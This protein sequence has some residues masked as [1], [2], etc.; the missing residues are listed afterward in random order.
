M[1]VDLAQWRAISEY[2]P[3]PW[4]LEAVE[5]HLRLDPDIS[6]RKLST[7]TGWTTYA[8]R[9][10]ISRTS[11]AEVAQCAAVECPLR[12]ESRAEVA[13]VSRSERVPSSPPPN[14][15]PHT[16][17]LKPPTPPPSEKTDRQRLTELVAGPLLR[18]LTLHEQLGRTATM[19]KGF[20]RGPNKNERKGC[21]ARLK[22]HTEAE[23][24]AVLR[25]AW[26]STHERAVFL[27]GPG[28]FI[29]DQTLWRPKNFETYLTFAL[30][31]PPVAA[32]GEYTSNGQG[33][34]LG[35]T[36]IPPARQ[37]KQ[38]DHRPFPDEE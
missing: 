7:L 19:G 6:Q 34:D 33:S 21:L 31:S 13:Q 26:T 3:R 2:L 17:L 8:I 23:V 1:S 11:R 15:S 4:P 29:R 32:A 35:G 36:R 38:G 16:P 14:G 18:L 24:E 37:F 27:R 30:D 22:D 25:W 28:G 5:L 10:L 9:T 20:S 12:A